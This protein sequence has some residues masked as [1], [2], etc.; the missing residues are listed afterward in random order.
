[1][2]NVTILSL[3]FLY[4]QQAASKTVVQYDKELRVGLAY[5][6]YHFLQT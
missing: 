3:G 6:F 4:Y 2:Y 1:M 5:T